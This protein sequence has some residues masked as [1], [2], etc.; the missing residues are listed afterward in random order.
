VRVRVERLFGAQTDDMG[1][2]LVRT[3]GTVRAK[4]KIGVKNSPTTCGASSSCAASTR[5]QHEHRA[6]QR[7]V[8]A[9]MSAGVQ[10]VAP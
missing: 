5:A 3:I 1:G 8:Q 9:A 7:A 4:A 6:N 10:S 2:T